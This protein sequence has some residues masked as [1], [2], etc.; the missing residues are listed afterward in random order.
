MLSQLAEFTL[1]TLKKATNGAAVM[2]TEIVIVKIG[3]TALSTYEWSFILHHFIFP[4]FA[5]M[6][7]WFYG[8]I[9]SVDELLIYF[10]FWI[11]RTPNTAELSEWAEG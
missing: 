2:T 7:L 3:V 1:E 8:E 10:I 11:M 5:H 9:L 6:L 4:S